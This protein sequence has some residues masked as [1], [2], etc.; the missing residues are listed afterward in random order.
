M[1]RR[2]IPQKEWVRFF[3]EFNKEHRNLIVSVNVKEKKTEVELI[4]ELPLKELDVNPRTDDNTIVQVIGGDSQNVTHFIDKTT[5]VEYEETEN[6][7]PK[8]I[9]IY[10]DTGSV[11]TINFHSM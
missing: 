4:K 6:K 9:S 2:D 5:K 8:Q 7:L 10:S 1:S 3:Y 11:T